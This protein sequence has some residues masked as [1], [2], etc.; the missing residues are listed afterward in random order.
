MRDLWILVAFVWVLDGELTSHIVEL[1]LSQSP[2]RQSSLKELVD[3]V[4][5]ST[6]SVLLVWPQIDSR[7]HYAYLELRHA[8]PTP[9]RREDGKAGPDVGKVGSKVGEEVG[10]DK[11]NDE[12]DH[13]IES[14]LE[15]ML[16]SDVCSLREIKSLPQKP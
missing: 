1:M 8:E 16:A 10:S 7:V 4:E 9:D 12:A 2:C 11:D 13:D 3:V 6:L 5:C 14:S 15:N